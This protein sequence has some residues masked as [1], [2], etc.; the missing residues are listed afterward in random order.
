MKLKEK[1]TLKLIRTKFKILSVFSKRKTAEKAFE[2]FCTPFTKTNHRIPSIFDIAEPLEFTLNHLKVNGYRWPA[3]EGPKLLILHGFG[4][5]AYKFHHY[6]R[7]FIDKGYEVLAFD[8][9][10]HGKSEGETVNALE[11]SQMILHIIKWYGPID[12]FL[13]HSFGGLALTLAMEQLPENSRYK[14]VFIAP[15][16][17]TVSAVDSAFKLLNLQD[18]VI[19]NEF[20]K[21]IVEKSG[22]P[23]EWFSMNRAMDAVKAK[24][25]WIH[26][27][28]DKVT[29]LAD[30]IPIRDKQLPNVKFMITQ[31]L[32]HRRIYRDTKVKNTVV[33]FL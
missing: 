32:G 31:G 12:S 1:I 2:L 24:T 25:L 16:T 13:A 10:A 22:K 3:T 27:E 7:R 19:K 33:E 6:V 23:K 17:E 4:S 9:P 26:D 14:I 11:Y 20:D 5:S 15:A 30:A 29:P 18:P 28:D 21:I 8:A